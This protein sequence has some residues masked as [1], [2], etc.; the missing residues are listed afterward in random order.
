MS[1]HQKRPKPD[2]E[3]EHNDRSKKDNRKAKRKIDKSYLR[4]I[5]DADGQVDPDAYNEIASDM[6]W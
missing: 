1:K 2:K 5:I 3:L 6:E 4:N